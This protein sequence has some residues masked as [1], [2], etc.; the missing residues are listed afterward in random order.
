MWGEACPGHTQA[1]WNLWS[2]PHALGVVESLQTA[3]D[4]CRWGG[5]T[6]AIISF[7]S[8]LC[9]AEGKPPPEVCLIF[10][11]C[12]PWCQH[13]CPEV[14]QSSSF[15]RNCCGCWWQ[16]CSLREVSQGLV[17]HQQMIS[18]SLLPSPPAPST[19]II[20]LTLGHHCMGRSST[21]RV[22]LTQDLKPPKRRDAPIPCLLQM[23][24]SLFRTTCNKVPDLFPELW[25]PA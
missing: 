2:P 22:F 21:L 15:S 9:S 12:A 17:K 24:L 11:C 5:E 13:R 7:W 23:S 18:G 10:H 20:P 19:D 8:T 14:A 16:F 6:V 1:V 25:S 3:Q 4:C